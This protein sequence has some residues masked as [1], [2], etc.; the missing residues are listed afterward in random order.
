MSARITELE[1][2]LSSAM[3]KCQ[4]TEQ[5]VSGR[6]YY[7]ELATAEQFRKIL[8]RSVLSG[9]KAQLHANQL[10]ICKLFLSFI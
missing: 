9:E 6:A 5:E 3:Q 1:D 4:E 2:E 10:H 7:Q 8:S